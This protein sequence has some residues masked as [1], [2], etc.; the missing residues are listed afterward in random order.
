METKNS[1]TKSVEK[2]VEN[3]E[4]NTKFRTGPSFSTSKYPKKNFTIKKEKPAD[5]KSLNL[6][7]KKQIQDLNPVE[8][9]YVYNKLFKL[10]TME[11]AHKF[12][13]HLISAFF[14]YNNNNQLMNIIVSDTNPQPI[15]AIT[16]KPLTGIFNVS[17]AYS[18]IGMKRMSMLGAAIS[19][20]EESIDESKV[21]ELQEMQKSLPD[22][23]RYCRVG[24]ASAKSDKFLSRESAYAL[25]Q[26]VVHMMNIES[27]NH[28]IKYAGCEDEEGGK[29]FE[30]EITGI[31]H[32]IGKEKARAQKVG[33][34]SHGPSLSDR[35]Y[36]STSTTTK[37]HQVPGFKRNEFKMEGSNFDKLNAL[38]EKM[39]SKK[40]E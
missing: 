27:E 19:N 3:K 22:E 15:D 40:E 29:F 39:E 32:M 6:P 4:I 37:K 31:V 13:K 33:I 36:S 28:Q 20:G 26:F 5:W 10:W 24:I 16:N 25:H 17:E 30:G 12:L 7:P 18:S 14:P 23:L 34:V 21:K 9:D 35:T 11:K 8:A 38:K 2:V 1:E